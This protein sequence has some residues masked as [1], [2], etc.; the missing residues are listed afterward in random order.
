MLLYIV[1]WGN[2]WRLLCCTR[3]SFVRLEVGNGS[4]FVFVSNWILIRPSR[5]TYMNMIVA[6]QPLHCLSFREQTQN[7]MSVVW[8]YLLGPEFNPNLQQIGRPSPVSTS[9]HQ[10]CLRMPLNED[11]SFGWYCLQVYSFLPLE[12]TSPS[13]DLQIFSNRFCQTLKHFVPSTKVWRTQWDY[14]VLHRLSFMMMKW[15]KWNWKWIIRLFGC[16]QMKSTHCWNIWLTLMSIWNGEAAEVQSIL[17]HLQKSVLIL[18]NMMRN[19]VIKCVSNLLRLNFRIMCNT[20]ACRSVVVIKDGDVRLLLKKVPTYN[21]KLTS[22]I[23]INSVRTCLISF[24][25]TAVQEFPLLSKLYLI[26]LMRALSLFMMPPE[27]TKR[28]SAI[29]VTTISSRIMTLYNTLLRPLIPEL[30]CSRG[31]LSGVILRV[32]KKPFRNC[33]WNELRT[34]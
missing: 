32:I 15:N 27:C 6:W 22:T 30:P 28:H 5:I 11:L 24:W 1:K 4:T 29:P 13:K 20:T 21:F 33:F 25:L 2:W 10:L 16:E 26:S 18:S 14:R 23:S 7:T 31:S 34:T 8:S 9:F 17:P 19:G 12:C 3:V